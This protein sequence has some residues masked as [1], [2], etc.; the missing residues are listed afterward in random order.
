MLYTHTQFQ[1]EGRAS[2]VIADSLPTGRCRIQRYKGHKRPNQLQ[3][4]NN[5]LSQVCK[6]T[7]ENKGQ[8]YMDARVCL[9]ILELGR[10]R[11]AY[12]A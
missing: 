8:L 5:E 10:I 7:W 11:T 1:K 12:D 3:Q 4:H 9:R 6:I 2:H